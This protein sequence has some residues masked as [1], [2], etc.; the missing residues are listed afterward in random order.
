MQIL[1]TIGTY[2]PDHS[3][4]GKRIRETY[5]RIQQT[6]A[7]R[8]SLK[9][10]FHWQVLT[11]PVRLPTEVVDDTNVSRIKEGKKLSTILVCL[12][13]L[14]RNKID[15]LHC[16]GLS[17][18]TMCSAWAA[19]ILRR[20][21][22]FELSIDPPEDTLSTTKNRIFNYPLRK[23]SG[24]IALTS[25]LEEYFRTVS[26][27]QPIFQR[28]NP[29]TLKNTVEINRELDP[30][31]P[32]LLL[33]RFSQRKG[34]DVAIRTLALLPEGEKLVLAGPVIGKQD[35][36]Y[37]SRLQAMVEQL[38]LQ[39]RVE[40]RT[41][42]ISEVAELIMQSHSVWCFSDREGLP[43]VVLEALW[44]GRPVFVNKSLGLQT[45][46]IDGQD[47]YNLP[48]AAEEKAVIIQQALL[49]GFN[50]EVIRL[51]AHKTFDLGK[52][53]HETFDFMSLLIKPQ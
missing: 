28:P 13:Y 16:V 33:G 37:V 42:F 47:G 6:V 50:T 23:A 30:N 53:S 1:V 36:K 21:Y 19:L 46:V 27:G 4:A 7:P 5:T 10:T 44:C 31:A 52:H 40:F 34:Q 26:K 39:E 48:N 45:I 29:V 3:G 11:H 38:N 41:E 20:P 35:E 14:R 49:A 43:N 22:I 25:R 12:K 24:Y 51:K 15:L 32:H 2:P 18:I 9:Q 17:K 8:S